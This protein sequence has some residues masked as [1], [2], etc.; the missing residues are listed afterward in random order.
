M[1]Q[2]HA[3]A[4]GP[5]GSLAINVWCCSSMSTGKEK[6]Q[7]FQCFQYFPPLLWEQGDNSSSDIL[8]SADVF[9][10]DPEL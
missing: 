5:G 6:M 7:T 8:L 1:G 2:S 4:P 9:F 3:R 10:M